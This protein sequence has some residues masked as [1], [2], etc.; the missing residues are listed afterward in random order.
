MNRRDAKPVSVHH[1]ATFACVNGETSEP[2]SESESVFTSD[3]FADVEV[4]ALRAER[5]RLRAELASRTEA[6]RQAL[7][8]LSRA[9]DLIAELRQETT[10]PSLDSLSSADWLQITGSERIPPIVED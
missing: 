8:D 10:T 3:A 4:G 7:R 1:N 5:D 6:W 2:S 9:E